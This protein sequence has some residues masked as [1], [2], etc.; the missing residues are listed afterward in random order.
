MNESKRELLA[1]LKTIE[2]SDAVRRVRSLLGAEGTYASPATPVRNEAGEL[3]GL[4]Q[5]RLKTSRLPRP[6]LRGIEN[7]VHRLQ[8]MSADAHVDQ[9]SFSGKEM[10]GSVFFASGSGEFLGDTIVRHHIKDRQMLAFEA[11]LI[12]P[13]RKSA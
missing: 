4:W 12:P 5:T 10:A 2:P 3:L 6:S 13:S 9:Y 7:L 8:A 1:K 11:Q